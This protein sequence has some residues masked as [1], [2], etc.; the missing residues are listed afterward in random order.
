LRLIVIEITDQ[1]R[2]IKARESGPQIV[3]D[4]S[5]CDEQRERSVRSLMTQVGLSINRFK[6]AAR[7]LGLHLASY[8]DSAAALFDRG[9]AWR[10]PVGIHRASVLQAF[11]ASHAPHQIVYL[12]PDADEELRAVEHECV[13][14][15]GGIIDSVVK[16]ACLPVLFKSIVLIAIAS[17]DVSRSLF[18]RLPQNMTTAKAQSLGVRCARLPLRQLAYRATVLN[19]DAVLHMLLAYCQ[20]IRPDG[21]NNDVEEMSNKERWRRAIETAIPP[22]RLACKVRSSHHCIFFSCIVKLLHNITFSCWIYR[23][24][25][26]TG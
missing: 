12:S 22:R 11:A 15:V 25:C 1:E 13:Y 24:R 3:V 19:V 17:F 21:G 26:V 9:D 16:K 2:F 7:P 20:P 14:V 23:F 5:F 10:W 8:T 4:L 6:S 18:R